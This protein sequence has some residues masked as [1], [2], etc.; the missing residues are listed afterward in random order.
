MIICHKW[1]MH[2][3]VELIYHAALLWVSYEKIVL[4]FLYY[5]SWITFAVCP[6]FAIDSIPFLGFLS[7]LLK[8]KMVRTNKGCS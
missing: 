1:V 5:M 8:N 4:V 3:W 2:K 6:I 7:S